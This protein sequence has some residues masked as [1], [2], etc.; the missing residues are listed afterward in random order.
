MRTL[1]IV[2][3]VLNLGGTVLIHFYGLPRI[4]RGDF[5]LLEEPSKTLLDQLR[6]FAVLSKLGVIL[7]FIGFTCQLIAAIRQR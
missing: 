4:E 6:A 5:L 3:L 1:N 7:L 2:G